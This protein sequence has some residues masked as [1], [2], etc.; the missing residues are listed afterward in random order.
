MKLHGT[1][2]ELIELEATLQWRRDYGSAKVHNRE[3]VM[4]ALTQGVGL[5]AQA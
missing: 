4:P 2:P 5:K 1:F 3:L